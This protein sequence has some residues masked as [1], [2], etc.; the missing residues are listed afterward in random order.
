MGK[1]A[2][3]AWA[4]LAV[5]C[6]CGCASSEATGNGEQVTVNNEQVTGSNEQEA[7]N[8]ELALAD[9]AGEE[10]QRV[11]VFPQLGHRYGVLSVAFS[12]DGRQVLSGSHDNTV[13]LWDVATGREI[14]TFTGHTVSSVAFNPDGKQIFSGGD[15][16][17][18]LWDVATGREIRTF[19]GKGF[20]SISPDG[21]KAISVSSNNTVELWDTETGQEI[22]TF[23]GHTNYVRSVA[24]SPD[25][26]Q[27]LSG[28][29]DRTVKLWNTETGQEIRTFSGH[30]HPVYSVAFSPDGMHILSGSDYAGDIKLWDITTGNEIRTF[31]G[32]Y[33]GD[34]VNSLAFSPDGKQ[35]LSGNDDN[36][37]ILWNTTTGQ[38]IRTFS[39]HGHDVHSVAFSPD[40][41]QVLSGSQ[42][43]TV[44]LW[45]VTTGQEIRTFSGNASVT[46]TAFSPDGKLVLS[47]SSDQTVKLWDVTVGRK[48]RTFV[49]HTETVTSVAFSPNG[50]QVLSGSASSPDGGGIIKLWDVDTGREIRPFLANIYH[51]DWITSV[52]FSPD[53]KQ[54]LSGSRDNAIK[55]WN[56]DTGREIRTFRGHISWVTSVAFSPDGRQ[57]LS[58]SFDDTVKLWDA[59]TGSEIRT[60]LG[61]TNEVRTVAFSPDGRQVL[62][63]SGGG[64]TSDNTAKLWDAA[65]GQEIRTFGHADYVEFLAFSP[66]GKQILSGSGNNVKLWDITTGQ[67]IRTFLG[68][69]FS[70]ISVAFSPD[71][72]Q[73]LSSS[74]DG[75][76]RL[77]D[78]AT[79]NEIAKIISFTDDEWIVITPDGYYNS[80][81][82]GDQYLNVR[83]ENN[84]YGMDQFSKIFYRPD[85]VERRLQGFPDPEGFRPE[86]KIQTASIPPDLKITKGEVDPE[87]RQVALS[88]TATDWIRQINDVQI[89]INGRLVGGNELTTVSADNL[90]AAYTRLVA[91]SIERQYPFTITL[92][93]DP[94]LNRIEIIAAN[95]FNYGLGLETIGVPQ[96]GEPPKGDL[97]LL[98]IGVNDYADNPLYQDLQYAVSDANRIIEAFKAQNE[99]RFDRVHT[100]L[101]TENEATKQNILY[102]IDDFFRQ[103]GR[104]DVSTLYVA[105]HGKTDNGVYCFFPSDTVFTSDGK[106]DTD[107][108][109]NVDELTRALD[110]PGRKIVMLDTCESG[111]V[112]TNQLVHTL[113]N[114]STVIFTASQED[115]SARENILYGGGFFTTGM[116]EGL[117][118]RAAEDGVVM[119]NTLEKYVADRVS[120]MSRNRQ[121]PATLV[122]DSYRDFVISIVERR[123]KDE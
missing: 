102:N 53:G 80:S 116:T 105:T 88:I 25:G 99:K 87:T 29:Q 16:G 118:G 58:G 31:P 54:V 42:D 27:V 51:G 57:I 117:G 84:V 90:E 60:F 77:W 11:E 85:V 28:S 18:K 52:A 122:P 98:A 72:R 104:D 67:E 9:V 15:G 12:P 21:T 81:P 46:S 38:E 63:G 7:D 115:E 62:S 37:V 121:R 44:I 83:I 65:T 17:A 30:T 34:G 94:G 93:L 35:F 4:G 100:R 78:V 66:D 112:D 70:V 47:G 89:I 41:M 10:G 74:N 39:G 108:V 20:S 103:A 8:K 24:F 36:T 43:A 69:T 45:N 71:G 55:L 5:I 49:G 40:G 32:R 56:V 3:F 75:T 13:K 22:I 106:F 111:G 68:H 92:Q 33:P 2:V 61:H 114:R 6:L 48:I 97:W 14:R 59:A 119:I 23:R 64:R 86:V 96:N 107:S 123:T 50:R 113:R 19:P 26:R 109:I 120:Q 110:I 91:S 101:I 76:T 1:N 73:V 95:E 82:R 79:G